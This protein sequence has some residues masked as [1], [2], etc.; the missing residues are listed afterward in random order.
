MTPGK[1]HPNDTAIR[2]AGQETARCCTHQ[3]NKT[4]VPARNQ[5]RVE[6]LG[7]SL[8]SILKYMF[9]TNCTWEIDWQKLDLSDG[10]WQMVIE[11]G[12]EYNFA[13]QMP[14]RKGDPNITYIVPSSL[15][16]GW[17]NRPV[18]FCVTTQTTRELIKRMLALMIHTGIK[19]LTNT[20]NT[21][22]QIHP[23]AQ[24]L[25]GEPPRT[26]RYSPASLWTISAM[27]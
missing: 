27:E 18:Y 16:M 23:Q 11:S 6:E 17:K 9:D 12:E 14:E 15:Q 21:A 25:H 8:L 1:N 13:F 4:T 26:S 2:T 10:F 3:S 19:N 24:H 7:W 20:K 22:S 5:S